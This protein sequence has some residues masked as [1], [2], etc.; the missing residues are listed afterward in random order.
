MRSN[1]L[2]RVGLYVLVFAIQSLY[3]PLN[4]GLKE[5]TILDTR[6][7]VYIPVWA[8]W[9]VP[10]AIAWPLWLAGY[11]WA[12]LRM[13]E[14]LYHALIAASV[15]ATATA[16][17]TFALFPT[18]VVRP[19]LTGSDW[20]TQWLRLLY[21]TDGVFNA[22]PSGHVYLTTIM[23]LFWSRWLPR[24]RWVWLGFALVIALS[25]L[26][27]RQHYIPDVL[28]G[29]ALAWMSYQIGTWLMRPAEARQ[30]RNQGKQ[31]Y[32]G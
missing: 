7:D 19:V 6:W 2:Q 27:T 14:K 17:S 26:F 30:E 16:I 12:V 23:A 32:P 10:Y 20:A 25:T 18:Y 13:P 5:G 9:I 31:A 15:L 4:H 11:A 1:L 22:F 24:W 28:G 3:L 21:A 29:A 8:I